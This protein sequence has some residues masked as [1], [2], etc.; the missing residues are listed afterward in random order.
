MHDRIFNLLVEQDEISWKSMIFD[1]VKKEGL[2]P[3]DIDVSNLA[4]KYIQKLKEMKELNLK[5][6]GK[7]VLAASILLRLKSN[8][9]VGDDLDEFDR[10][11]AGSEVSEEEFYDELAQE[12]A[13]GEE[14]P[15]EKLNFELLP[16]LPQPRKRKVSVFDLVKALE[17][18]LE[19]KQRRILRNTPPDIKAP[20][21]GFDIGDAINKLDQRINNLIDAREQLK[22]TDLLTENTKDEIV[23][24]F[25]PLL[26]LS[27]DG[28]INLKQDVSFGDIFITKGG[29]EDA[30]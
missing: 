14:I 1:L 15:K 17:K 30:D 5:V 18:A 9:L 13:R 3:W 20:V 25:L 24:T 6:S 12:L 28:T 29:E 16:R 8:K 10:L 11:I 21:K 22:F 26:H 19:V 7:V 2:D 23:F 27:N 4:E